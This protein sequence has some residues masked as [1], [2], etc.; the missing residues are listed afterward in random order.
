MAM[1]SHGLPTLPAYIFEL[2]ALLG[3]PQVDLKRVGKVIRTDPSLTAQL[4]RLCNSAL[5]TVRRRVLSVEEAAILMGVERLRTLVL[6]CSLMEFT[7]RQF[8]PQAV[9]AFWQHS[10][11][12][13]MI[14]ERIALWIDFPERE[15]AYLGGLLHDLGLLPLWLVAAEEDICSD[16]PPPVAWQDSVPAEREYFGLDHCTAGRALGMSW[17]FLPSFVDVFEHHHNPDEASHDKVLVGIVSSADHFCNNHAAGLESDLHRNGATQAQEDEFMKICLPMLTD[18]ERTT[19]TEILEAEYL[20][21]LP[22]LEVGFLTGAGKT[23]AAP[24]P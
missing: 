5:Y 14:S 2:N 12:A 1:L 4:I 13:G 18:E 24:T 23:M 22:L 21:L 9:Q 17:N 19:L 16:V 6:S 15:Q 20:H 10:L 8:S 3:S 11:M 7:G